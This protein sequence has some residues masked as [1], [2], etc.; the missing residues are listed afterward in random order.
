[1][2][3]F[4]WAVITAAI[5]GVVPLIE[6]LGLVRSDPTVGVFAR[7]FGV[8]VGVVVFGILWSPWKAVFSLS[9]RSFVLLALGGFLA[10]FV[11]QLA[12]YHALKTGHLSQITPV[13]GSYPLVAALLG[14][15]LL[16]EPVTTARVVGVMLIVLGVLLLRR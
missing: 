14:W 9:V 13:S 8:V 4:W 16:H 15:V 2:S 10:S 3:A 1:V 11:G 6:K 5:W 12:F 7:S